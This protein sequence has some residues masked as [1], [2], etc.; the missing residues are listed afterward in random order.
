ML[1]RM[2]PGLH[3]L[4]GHSQR[5][6]PRRRRR[7]PEL[8]DD[9]SLGRSRHVDALRALARVNLLSLASGRLWAEVARLHRAG[10][11][12]VR[13]LDVACGGGDVL[14]ALAR[15][16]GRSGVPVELHGC[17]ASPVALDVARARVSPA[18]AARFFPLDVERE[19]LPSG[20]DLV[21]CSL[22]LHHLSD[23]SAVRLLGAMAAATRDTVLVQDLR[24]TRLGY[25]FAFVGLHAL[26]TS[27]VARRD[28]L[29]SVGAAFTIPEARVLC[30][31]A[32]MEGARVRPSW[33]QRFVVR[34]RPG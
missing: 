26:T 6:D 11:D 9:P 27:D 32:G 12:R 13:V 31:A 14:A 7:L 17:D 8:M 25:L 3:P 33:P 10:R 4:A 15:R 23:E 28:G 20:Y 34:W 2:T 18:D 1:R 30:A 24:R 21:C 16:A 19:A 22:F 5:F 29:I